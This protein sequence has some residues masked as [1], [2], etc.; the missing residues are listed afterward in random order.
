MPM[1]A[2]CVDT[3]EDHKRDLVFLKKLAKQA[4]EEWDV[5]QLLTLILGHAYERAK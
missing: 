3:T 1:E 4:S 2:G 5:F